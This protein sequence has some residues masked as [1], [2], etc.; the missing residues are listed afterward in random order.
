[1]VV[2]PKCGA[3]A[4]ANTCSKCGLPFDLCVCVT[5]ERE[6]EKIRIT[7]EMRRF[8]KPITIIEGIVENAKDVAKQLKSKLACGGTVKEG[9]IELQGDHKNKVKD[10]LVKL[11]YSE[12]QIEIS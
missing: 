9:H 7:T 11:G 2:C 10:I 8:S 12:E 4:T 6:A 1:M 3:Q 5:I